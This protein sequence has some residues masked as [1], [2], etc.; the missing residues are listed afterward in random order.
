MRTMFKKIGTKLIIAVGF[1]SILIIGVYAYFNIQA[2][3]DALLSEAE[4]H[5]NQLSE[6]VKK[7]TR[8]GMLL[9]HRDYVLE[10]I[11][12]IKQ[13]PYIHEVRIFNKEGEINYSSIPSEI[14]KMVDKHAESC[15][16]CHA[17]NQPIERLPIEKR[18][19]IYRPKP[20]SS[21]ILGIIN[22]IYNEK[23]CWEAACHMHPP[24]QKVLGVLD[25]TICLTELDKQIESSEIKLVVFAI[26]AILAVSFI[27]GIFVKKLIDTPVNEILK[28]TQHVALGNLSY[29]ITNNKSDE[30][31]MLARSFNNMTHKLS[32]ARLQLFQSDKMASLGRLAAGVAHEINNPLTGVLTYS[33]YLLKHTKDNK[34]LQDDLAVIVRETIRSREIVKSLLDF[35]R[36]TVPQ[37]NKADIN[38]IIN[39][40]ISVVSNQLSLKGIKLIKK[41]EPGF[42]MIKVD[43]NQIQQVIINLLVNAEDAIEKEG[44]HI[45]V[46]SS[47]LYLSPYGITQIKNA[48]CPKGHNLMENSIK[49]DG[50]PSIKVK[51]NL[52][53][54]EGLIYLDPIYGKNRHKLEM[55][56]NINKPVEINC[57]KCNISLISASKKCPKCGSFIYSFEV[58]SRGNVEGCCNIEC[59]YQKWETIDSGGQKR[60]IEIKISDTGKG[61]A[62]EFLGRIFEPF[63]TT[64]DQKGTGLGLAVTWG[65]IDNHNGTI[66]VESEV[67]KGTTFT[68][69]LP[70]SEN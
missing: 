32:E 38:E 67:G 15:Y 9:N 36:Q 41:L 57:P 55:P 54:L 66:N 40:S 42:P 6:T 60:Y 10:I 50:L 34:A 18:T 7:S 35:S 64:K 28:A 12:T 8:Y 48:T 43:S 26:I 47:L 69:H 27:I 53:G 44:G 22:P 23:S 59:P 25:I 21:R 19:R 31:G 49:I 17:A 13:E 62:K 29:R 1:T 11:N 2:Q 46:A 61:I 39:R 20:D 33:S 63:F 51:A 37:K 68:V 52:E 70:I 45:T 4:K 24:E 56:V 16:A 14:G 3:S 65:I 30:L 5:G 58:P